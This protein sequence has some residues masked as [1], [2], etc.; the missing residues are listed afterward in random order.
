MPH[1]VYR[2]FVFSLAVAFHLNTLRRVAMCL[3]VCAGVC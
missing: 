2:I 3:S 1:H